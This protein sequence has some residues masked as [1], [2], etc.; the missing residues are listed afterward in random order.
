MITLD[1]KDNRLTRQE[2]ELLQLSLYYSGDLSTSNAENGNETDAHSGA[3]R[4]HLDFACVKRTILGQP[5]YNDKKERVG[6]VDDITPL[7]VYLASDESRFATGA[8]FCVD[9][10]VTI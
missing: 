10:G 7:V 8:L 9:G 3:C 6:T 2:R 1:P 4:R 5:V